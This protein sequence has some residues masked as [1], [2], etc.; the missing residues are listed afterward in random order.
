MALVRMQ[1]RL[2]AEQYRRLRAEARRR[3]T[4]MSALVRECLAAR[5]PPPRRGKADMEA[6]MAFVGT[7]HDTTA[8]VAE[9]HDD[10]LAEVG[11]SEHTRARAGDDG[12]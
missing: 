9:R 11:G 10:Y 7:G 6:A 1:I 3:G 12:C 5:Y 8:D 4:S 2:E